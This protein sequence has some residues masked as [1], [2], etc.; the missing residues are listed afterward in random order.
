MKNNINKMKDVINSGT[1]MY[2]FKHPVLESERDFQIEL[3]TKNSFIFRLHTR[4]IVFTVAYLMR[5]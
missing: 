5:L 1:D 3:T 4:S 2:A